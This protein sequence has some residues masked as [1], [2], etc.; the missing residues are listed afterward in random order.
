M[1][2]HTW[3]HRNGL[4]Q[5]QASYKF[6]QRDGGGVPEVTLLAI[7]LLAIDD[8]RGK[9]NHFFFGGVAY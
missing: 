6:Q 9:E 4:E 2:L 5:D 8:Y 1:L 7:E 3:T